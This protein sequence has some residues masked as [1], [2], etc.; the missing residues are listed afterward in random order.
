M[1]WK[2]LHGGPGQV[3]LRSEL[4]AS[5]ARY[6]KSNVTKASQRA[7]GSCVTTGRKCDGY[8]SSSQ[9][10]PTFAMPS[11]L[12]PVAAS[13]PAVELRALEF[14][15]NTTSLQLAGFLEGE[16]WKRTALQLSLSEPAIRQAL[17]ALGS[18][19]EDAGSANRALS[20]QLYIRAIRSTIDKAAIGDISVPIVVV[21]YNTT[22]RV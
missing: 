16:F 2:P 10:A 9:V 17:A 19:H 5:P 1:A 22:L 3:G 11:G 21:K 7:L 20:E 18:L 13:I 15:Y 12:Q 4:A 8:V 6:G 14:F